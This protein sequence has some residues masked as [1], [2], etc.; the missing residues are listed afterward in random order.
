MLHIA[1][2]DDEALHREHTALLTQK[3]LSERAPEIDCFDGAEA[4]LQAMSAGDYTPDIAVLDIQMDGMDGIELAHRLNEL[5]PE[6]RIIFLTSYLSFAPDVYETRHAYFVLKNQISERIGAA[7]H[8][9]LLTLPDDELCLR[10]KSGGAAR[11]LPVREVLYLERRLHKTRIATTSEEAFTQTAPQ[12][13]VSA[14]PEGLFIHCHQSFW[15][16]REHISELAKGVF[17]LT[18][19][20]RIPIS[21]TY[22]KAAREAFLSSLHPSR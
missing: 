20:E 22:L 3:E 2:C 17:V 5:A 8:K 11:L 7:L 10:F 14:L 12:E 6:C 13:L 15:V 4:L 16:N 1:I 18:D 19:G 9:A 21:R